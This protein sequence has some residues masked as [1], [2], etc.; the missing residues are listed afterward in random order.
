MHK[1]HRKSALSVSSSEGMYLSVQV[2]FNKAAL[3]LSEA[4]PQE[5]KNTALNRLLKVPFTPSD[6]SSKKVAVVSHEDFAKYFES[7]EHVFMCKTMID[8]MNC[9]SQACYGTFHCALSML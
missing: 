7:M 6:L 5:Q 4:I 3:S 1:K 8:G 9:D 2:E